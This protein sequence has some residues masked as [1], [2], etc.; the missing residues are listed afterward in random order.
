MN[1]ILL[2]GSGG[3]IGRNILEHFRTR[4]DV[5]APRS[6]ELNLLDTAAVDDYFRKHQFEIGRA[7][8]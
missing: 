3:F 8:V 2:T 1:K 7:H 4:Y 5:F 6:Y